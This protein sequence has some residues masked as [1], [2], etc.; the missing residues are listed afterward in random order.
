MRAAGALHAATPA[1]LTF[2]TTS[3]GCQLAGY[4]NKPCGLAVPRQT[5]GWHFQS[6]EKGTSAEAQ[7]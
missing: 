2:T 7:E 4:Q 1:L 5:N 6:N 3:N